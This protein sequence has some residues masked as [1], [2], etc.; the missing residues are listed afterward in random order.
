VS[1]GNKRTLPVLGFAHR[2]LDSVPDS[3]HKLNVCHI[4]RSIPVGVQFW[5]R[6]CG[7]S[8]CRG[9]LPERNGTKSQ[10]AITGTGNCLTVTLVDCPSTHT[11]VS[12]HHEVYSKLQPP[13][14]GARVEFQT[15]VSA[16]QPCFNA[17]V[18]SHC[19]EFCSKVGQLPKFHYF[20][21]Q[22]GGQEQ[23]L[24][25]P[26]TTTQQRSCFGN[27]HRDDQLSLWFSLRVATC[28]S[29]GSLI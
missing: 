7:I 4:R 8:E 19:K 16:V 28:W 14:A 5:R 18:K 10:K 9:Y 2:G 25:Q 17:P 3:C 11:F 1:R 26:T 23:L 22:S 6:L 24:H 12:T 21:V 15:I 13:W 20:C 29:M 27:E